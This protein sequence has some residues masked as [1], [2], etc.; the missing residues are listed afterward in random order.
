MLECEGTGARF[1][2][3]RTYKSLTNV[4][5]RNIGG[6]PGYK[7]GVFYEEY[8]R[9]RNILFFSRFQTLIK[10]PPASARGS[11]HGLVLRRPYTQDLTLRAGVAP[12][13]ATSRIVGGLLS[14]GGLGWR[15]TSPPLGGPGT[16]VQ[17]IHIRLIG[18]NAPPF[19][20]VGDRQCTSAPPGGLDRS[21][22]CDLRP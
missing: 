7:A 15:G 6:C 9:T 3:T 17:A 18:A 5:H 12:R 10:K 13:F 14:G 21:I 4:R 1:F 19:L 20:R 2:G 22:I 11:G 8:E 16:Y